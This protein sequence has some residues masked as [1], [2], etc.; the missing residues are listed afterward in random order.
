MSNPTDHL[1]AFNLN[2]YFKDHWK[3]GDYPHMPRIH[4]A[5]GFNVS[6]QVGKCM[7][8]TPRD[9]EGPWIEVECG[10]PSEKCDELMQWAESPEE[11]TSTVYGYVPVHVVEAVI[12]RH[13]G[14][15]APPLEAHP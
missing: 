12:N 6:V 5:D 8:C 11:P 15:V 4:C 14:Q 1:P 3:E 7:Y 9:S 13:G 10:Y 2:Q